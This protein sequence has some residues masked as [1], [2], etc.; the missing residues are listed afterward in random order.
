MPLQQ[1]VKTGIIA[2]AAN[3]GDARVPTDLPTANKAEVTQLYKDGFIDA[4]V[5]IMRI[6]A[7]LALVGAVMGGVFIRDGEVGKRGKE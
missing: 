2:Q 1:K 4:Y 7:G 6:S 5:R 3:L